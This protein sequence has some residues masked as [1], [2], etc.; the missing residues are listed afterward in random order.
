MR[1]HGTLMQLLELHVMRDLLDWV[2]SE[3][4]HSSKVMAGRGFQP[5]YFMKTTHQ[6]G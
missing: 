3:V 5:P 6:I 1:G 2:S 4:C